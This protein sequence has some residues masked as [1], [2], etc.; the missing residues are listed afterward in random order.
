MICSLSIGFR[1]GKHIATNLV[2][3]G[4][5]VH[6]GISISVGEE[7]LH[8]L[9]DVWAGRAEIFGNRNDLLLYQN[10]V[11]KLLGS[12]SSC[13]LN[14]SGIVITITASGGSADSI[15]VDSGGSTVLRGRGH[16]V[17]TTSASARLQSVSH[18]GSIHVLGRGQF[19]R[20]A[21]LNA[22]AWCWQLTIRS[23]DK[24]FRRMICRSVDQLNLIRILVHVA[25]VCCLK[26]TLVHFNI[27]FLFWTSSLQ[28]RIN[29]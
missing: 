15:E 14:D 4:N 28:L 23:I 19:V 5:L 1:G 6:H 3:S 20:L 24:F 25:A 27:I 10:R 11:T 7:R 9:W 8:M 29:R 16:P 17:L 18:S 2:I 13:L 26:Q 22:N 12:C 21:L